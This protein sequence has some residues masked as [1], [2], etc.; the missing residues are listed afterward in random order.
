MGKIRLLIIETNTLLREGISAILKKQPMLEVEAITGEEDKLE[1]KIIQFKPNVILMNSGLQCQD[2]VQVVQWICEK[3]PKTKLVFMSLSLSQ[4]EIMQFMDAGVTGFILKEAPT[5]EYVQTITAVAR[6][7]TILPVVKPRLLLPSILSHVL[8]IGKIDHL[9]SVQITDF[10]LQL[11]QLISE[12][13]SNYEIGKKLAIKPESVKLHV[14]KLK[15]NLY[16]FSHLE[17]LYT[18]ALRSQFR[19]GD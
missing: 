6:G 11:L 9:K 7:E 4:G 12:G 5:L 17:S 16:L 14:Y 18:I 3:F 15:Q 10:E 2:S 13:K 1:K 8:T 19:N